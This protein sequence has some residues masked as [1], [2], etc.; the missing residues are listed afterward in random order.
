MGRNAWESTMQS[1]AGL[2]RGILKMPFPWNVW[3]ALLGAVNIVGGV[4]FIQ[5]PAGQA[6][7]V[8]I[9]LAFVIMVVIYKRFGF[10]RLLGLGH[11]I[12]WIPLV[13]FFVILLSREPENG[14]YTWWLVSVITVNTISLIIDAVDVIRYAK[15]DR[16]PTG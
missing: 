11:L 16:E 13:G 4:W 14:P 9:M 1:V 12:A 6:A 7:L 8:A 5:R 10:V 15:G 3:V 2:T